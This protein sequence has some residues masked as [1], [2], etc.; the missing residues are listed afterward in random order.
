MSKKTVEDKL[1]EELVTKDLLRSYDFDHPVWKQ[2]VVDNIHT[3]YEVSNIGTVRNSNRNEL[4]IYCHEKSYPCVYL[5]GFPNMMTVHRL[6]AQ[7]FIPN[8]ENKPQVNHI[9]GNRKNNWVGNLEWVTAKENS[10]H[11]WRTGIVDNN[12]ENQGNSIYKP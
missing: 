7:A 5:Q 6:V 1:I 11:A 8:P 9:D 10:E 12:G 2:I 4:K 3:E